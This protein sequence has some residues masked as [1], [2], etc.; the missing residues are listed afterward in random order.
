MKKSLLLFSTLF[1]GIQFG[2]CQADAVKFSVANLPE[3][4]TANANALFKTDDEII[5]I[6]SASRYSDKVHQVVTL[7]NA[8]ASHY[9]NFS[10]PFDKFS[11]IESVEIKLYDA[12]GGLVKKYHKK[13]FKIVDADDDMSL[14]IDQK[15]LKLQMV[16]AGYPCTIETEYE[17]KKTGYVELPDWYMLS[18]KVSVQNSSFTVKVATGLDIRYR[19]LR[20]EIKPTIE[21]GKDYKIYNWSAKNLAAIKSERNSYE[22]MSY[23]PKIEIAPMV[24]EYDG[25]IGNFE[26]WKNFGAWNYQLYEDSN[27]FTPAQADEFKE[28]TKDAKTDKEKIKILYA[29][30]QKNMRY[31]SVQL[32]IGGFKPFGVQYVH[33]KKYGDCKALTNYMRYMLKVVDIKSYPALINAGANKVAADV[34]F[35][36]DPFNHVILCVP[37]AKDSVWLECTSSTRQAGVLGAFT[38]NKNALLLTEKGGILVSTPKSKSIENVLNTKTEI[39]LNE[40]G[41]S[42]TTSEIFCSGD[43]LEL[44]YEIMKQNK[45]NQKTILIKYLNYKMP[46]DFDLENSRDSSNGK[47]FTLNLSYDQLYDFKSGNKYFYQPRVNSL[48]NEEPMPE[49]LRK[50]DYL[51]DFPYSKTDTTIFHLPGENFVDNLPAKRTIVNSYAFYSSEFNKNGHGNI[52]TAVAKFDLKNIK[53]SPNAYA[54]VANSFQQIM[55]NEN[56]KIIIKKK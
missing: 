30:L 38:Q 13:D 23:Y 32:G 55:Q 26:S 31:V 1:A 48:F 19:E 41:G 42:K 18:P 51:F 12:I 15:I 45:N 2:L 56:E 14:F 8:D 28:M 53:V 9:L 24:F 6:N 37:F 3:T 39:Y 29:N 46:E 49:V 22:V 34:N 44:F 50:F 17:I 47:V 40:E 4:L 52:I 20:T 54:D 11:K 43:F 7:L 5:E 27:P 35:P 16:N 21:I 25:H 10:L 36:A 33:E